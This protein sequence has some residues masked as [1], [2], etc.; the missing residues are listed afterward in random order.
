MVKRYLKRWSASPIIKE[1]QIKT[2]MRYYLKPVRM[3]IMKRQEIRSVDE[4]VKK[5]NPSTLMVGG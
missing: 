5:R 4:D 2:T 3:A 1:I